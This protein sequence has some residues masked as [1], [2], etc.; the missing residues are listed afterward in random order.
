MPPLNSYTV[1]L[2]DEQIKQVREGLE[3]RGFTFRE[4]PYTHFGAMKDKLTVNAYQSG[5][6]LVQGKGVE[7]FVQFFLEPEV[8]KEAKLGYEYELD[9]TLLEPRIGVDESGKGDYFGPLAVAG[10]FLNRQAIES[11][12]DSGVRDSKA[13][14]SDKRIFDLAK[15]IRET[16]GAVVQLVSISPRAYNDL[17]VKMGNVNRMLAWGHARVIENALEKIEPSGEQCVRAVADQFGDKRL[18][19]RALMKRG[20]AIELVQRHKAESD[21]AVAAASIMAREEFV[22]KLA[23]LGKQYEVEMPKGASNL[24]IEAGREFVKKHGA[25]K[26]NEVAKLHFQT[27]QKVTAAA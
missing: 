25:E 27:T 5:K 17:Y 12:R 18:I 14:G 23:A 16:R 1:K 24:V 21:L 3:Q 22:R 9:P 19:E 15:L 10:V 11:L 4:V 2:T 13:I 6:L 20:R 7:E 8:L 26:L